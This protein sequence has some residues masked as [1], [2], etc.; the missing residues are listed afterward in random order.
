MSLSGRA[1]SSKVIEGATK[2]AG[3][4]YSAGSV[5]TLPMLDAVSS[6]GAFADALRK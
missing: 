5:M 6:D 1:G 2:Y 4:T 3:K